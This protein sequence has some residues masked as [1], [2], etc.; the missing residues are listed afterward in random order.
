MSREERPSENTA[1]PLS[2][3]DGSHRYA[4]DYMRQDGTP[5]GAVPIIPDFQTA[6]DWTY[7]MGVRRGQLPGVSAEAN[8]VVSPLW[9][10]ERG[11][12]YCRGFR[13]ETTNAD[14]S[15]TVRCDFPKTY[16]KSLAEKG[17]WEWV[18][19]GELDVGERYAYQVCAYP[20]ASRIP[21]TSALEAQTEQPGGFEIEVVPERIPLVKSRL[22]AFTE[23]AT[24]EG[25]QTDGDMP[26]FFAQSVVDEACA[27]AREA[28]ENETGGILVG[29]IHQDP[30]KPEVFIEVVAQLPAQ[31]A[32][33]TT[34]SFSFTHETWSAAD[35]AIALRGRGELILGWWHSHPRFCNP[36]CPESRWKNCLLASPFFSGDDIHL[37]RVC[38]P[39]PYQV[40]LL[41]SDLPAS[42]PT[43]ALFGWRAGT[44][45]TRGYFT[46]ACSTRASEANRNEEKRNELNPRRR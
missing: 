38:F 1:P 46:G 40:A 37:H 15:Q 22:D 7:F 20:V 12:P 43:P 45:S 27:L 34:S 3:A 8:G 2:H 29:Q 33:A 28:G 14:G 5:L 17:S 16:F 35:V 10:D 23:R 26:V 25:P 19:K 32:E 13:V 24:A 44:V 6:R 18:A 4:I 9:C 39:Q 30:S 42:G 31:Y 41:I 11:E 21:E 36:E